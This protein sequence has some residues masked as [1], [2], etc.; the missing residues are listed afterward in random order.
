MI[1]IQSDLTKNGC[2]LKMADLTKKALKNLK[3]SVTA[4]WLPSIVGHNLN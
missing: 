1:R 3:A 4:F 2:S